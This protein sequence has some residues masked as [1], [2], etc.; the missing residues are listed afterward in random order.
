MKNLKKLNLFG[1]IINISNNMI[2]AIIHN[3]ERNSR[4]LAADNHINFS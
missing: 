4:I 2:P 3:S 1:S